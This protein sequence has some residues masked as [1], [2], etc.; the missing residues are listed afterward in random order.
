MSFTIK[1]RKG[2]YTLNIPIEEKHKYFNAF[3]TLQWKAYTQNSQDF[4]T[5]YDVILLHDSNN[6]SLVA[7]TG[8]DNI[9]GSKIQVKRID[10]T[11]FFRLEHEIIT[12]HIPHDGTNSFFENCRVMVVH[13][14]NAMTAGSIADWFK[15]SYIYYGLSNIDPVQSCHQNRLRE[16]SDYT[17]KFKILYDIPF[18]MTLNESVKQMS[19]H[20]EPR[21][22][23]T[24]ESG[25]L[26][27]E[28]FKNTYAFLLGPA[29]YSID[30]DART[31]ELVHRAVF[32]NIQNMNNISGGVNVKYTFYD[33]N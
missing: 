4:L 7:G 21:K 16:S 24:F 10:Y 22:N 19:F 3:F 13:F 18:K 6:L 5:Q 2:N 14:D 27:N 15:K 31:F 11:F 29:N 17:G 32:N 33:L 1:A 8:D 28:D 25:T 30:T 26:T 12:D 9:I 20:L 23:L